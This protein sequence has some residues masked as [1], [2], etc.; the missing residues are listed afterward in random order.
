VQLLSDAAKSH[1]TPDLLDKLQQLL[2]FLNIPGPIRKYLPVKDNITLRH[3]SVLDLY[4]E[5]A[6][7]Q[8]VDLMLGSSLFSSTSSTG[9]TGAAFFTVRLKEDVS[10]HYQVLVYALTGGLLPAWPKGSTAAFS[11]G[12]HIQSVQLPEG[13]SSSSSSISSRAG[14]FKAVDLEKSPAVHGNAVSD[15]N[16]RDLYERISVGVSKAVAQVPLRGSTGGLQSCTFTASFS[17]PFTD[18]RAWAVW[19]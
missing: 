9:S 5:E 14:S 3:L 13:T 6:A 19:W 15:T 1:S 4:I 12:D 10:S 17:Y 11:T 8:A 7:Q 2:H 16:Y 18:T